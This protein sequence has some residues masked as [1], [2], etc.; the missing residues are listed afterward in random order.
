VTLLSVVVPVYKVQGYLRQCLDSILDQSFTDL[1]LIAVDDCSPDHSGEILAEYAA[2]DSR[3]RVVSL[4][5]NVGL[6]GARNVGLDLA[7]GEYVWFVDSDD[8]LT[9]GSLRAVATQLA[10]TAPDVLIVDQR[11]VYWDGRVTRSGLAARF[12]AT[13]GTVFTARERPEVLRVLHTAWNKIVR[14]DFLVGLGLRFT[15]GWYEDVSFTYPLVIAAGRITVLNRVCVNYR[16]RRVGAITRTVGERHVEVFDHWERVFALL[17]EWGPEHDDL[18]PALFQRM[19]WHCLVVLGNADRIPRRSRR[20]FFERLAADYARY[21]PPGG[22]PLPA[23]RRERL[24]HRLL[25]KGAWRTF[26]ALRLVDRARGRACRFVERANRAAVPPVRQA[27]RLAVASVHRA[28]YHMQRQLPIDGR[29][30]V[31]SAYSARGYACNPAA[32]HAK[33]SEL[34]PAIR[35]VWV[36]RRDRVGAMPAGVPY[37]V[38]GSFAYYRALARAKWMINNVNFPNFVVKRRGSVHLQTHHGTPVKVMGLDQQ[39]YLAGANTMNFA[40]LMR[41]C[42]RWDYSITSNAFSTEAWERAYPCSYETLEYGYP[43]NDRLVTAT[44]ADVAAAR[45]RVGVAP[46]DLVV[47]YAPTHREYDR[48]YRPPIDLD[49]LAGALGEDGRLLVRS[50]YLGPD[51]APAAPRARGAASVRD[52]S[53]VEPV[54]DLYLA[55]DVLITDYSSAMFDYALLDRPI[56]IYAPDWEA[57]RLHRGVTF[58]LLADPPGAV[59]TTAA[60]LFDLFRTGAHRG[61]L[62]TKA[63][64]AFRRRFCQ[65]DDGYAAERVVRRIFL[66]KGA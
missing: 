21:L 61:D 14:R 10:A 17:D 65:Y 34:A 27:R 64:A 29:L 57:Y 33:A 22:Y 41:R 19:V 23:S 37:V 35:G 58:D 15:P 49:E 13:A 46:G 5:G 18:R 53:D 52:V 62:A 26:A 42:D 66:Q 6:G 39:D 12:G 8:W 55:A 11:R 43:R 50:H 60:G 48:G 31:Y 36:V 40:A 1:E 38:D 51:P 4:D 47:L 16:Q 9:E 7:V 28:Y 3:V 45:A 24:K 59:A 63:R 56:V 2:R 32:I 30:A 25:A 54:E 44:E 20:V